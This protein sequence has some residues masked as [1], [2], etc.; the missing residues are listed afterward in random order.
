M[1]V[2]AN[3]IGTSPKGLI[4]EQWKEFAKNSSDLQSFLQ[5]AE[6]DLRSWIDSEERLLRLVRARAVSKMEERSTIMIIDARIK[7]LEEFR[8]ALFG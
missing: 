3:K 5:K 7:E 6:S 1:Q 8:K 2:E 4:I